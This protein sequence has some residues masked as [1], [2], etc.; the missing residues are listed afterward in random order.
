[1]GF[2]PDRLS[3]RQE[4]AVASESTYAACQSTVCQDRRSATPIT[5]MRAERRIHVHMVIFDEHAAIAD[6]AV[7]KSAIRNEQLT[8]QQPSA[9]HTPGPPPFSLIE[10]DASRGGQQ[11]YPANR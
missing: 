11:P 4:P 5:I 8:A 1:L 7:S 3:S 9:S 10:L 6:S 2:D